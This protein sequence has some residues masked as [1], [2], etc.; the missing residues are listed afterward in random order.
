[1]TASVYIYNGSLPDVKEDDFL[2]WLRE[3]DEKWWSE[4]YAVEIGLEDYD[5]LKLCISKQLKS[6]N[7]SGVLRSYDGVNT[8]W[9]LN[10]II[11]DYI[12]ELYE[13]EKVSTVKLYEDDTL[14]RVPSKTEGVCL[15]VL[16]KVYKKH[17]LDDLN[18]GWRE[19][20]GELSGLLADMMGD[21]KYSEWLDTLSLNNTGE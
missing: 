13:G 16:K 2:N 21:E 8:L 1:M 10:Q 6:L 14:I 15:E 12:S 4:G 19:L 5:E 18:I 7:D 3:K 9:C 20:T 11:K 17:V